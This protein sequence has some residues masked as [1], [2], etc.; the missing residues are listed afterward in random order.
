MT[1]KIIGS[2]DRDEKV[3]NA[4]LKAQDAADTLE[5]LAKEFEAIDQRS[6]SSQVT[7]LL[8]LSERYANIH[9]KFADLRTKRD[10]AN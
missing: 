7:T 9:K 5:N 8:Y 6:V 1:T 4:M 3:K 10:A 2:I